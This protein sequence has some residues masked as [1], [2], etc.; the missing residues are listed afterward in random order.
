MFLK[1]LVVLILANIIFVGGLSAHEMWLEPLDYTRTTNQRILAHEKVGQDFKGNEYSYLSSSY[2]SLEF[3]VNNQ[4]KAVEAR[5]GD[6][7]A[8]SVLPQQQGLAILSAETTSS[9]LVYEKMGAFE[10][11]VKSKGL[12]WVL[13]AHKKRGLPKNNFSEVYR[14]YAKSLVKVGHG[15]GNDKA[16]GLDFE[17]VMETN[18]YTS[19]SKD[20][21]NAQLLWKGKVFP[22]AHV[23]VFNRKGQSLVK[24]DLLTDKDGRVVIPRA[25]GGSFLINAVQMIEP[26]KELVEQTGAVWESLWASMTYYLE[27]ELNIGQ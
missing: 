5:L 26:S 2:V 21:I 7:P 27:P 25:H 6:I 23:S 17:W 4:T 16:L 1:R 3:T 22:N 18:P 20:K 14:R 8:V 11:F 13:K 9:S 19:S 24:T 10:S 12:D 15:K